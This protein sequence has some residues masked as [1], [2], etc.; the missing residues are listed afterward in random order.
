MSHPMVDIC[1]E[2]Q[3]TPINFGSDPLV[4]EVMETPAHT[5]SDAPIPMDEIP[6]PNDADYYADFAEWSGDR[7]RLI[8]IMPDGQPKPFLIEDEDRAD[9]CVN[10]IATWEAEIKRI[11]AQTARR[12]DRLTRQ[13]TNFEKRFLPELEQ[14]TRN[15]LAARGNKER[16]L[17]LL[18]G[19]CVLRSVPANVIVSNKEDA[20]N[21]LRKNPHDYEKMVTVTQDESL[22]ARAYKNLAKSTGELL[23][24]VEYTP[25]RETFTVKTGGN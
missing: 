14:Y 24:G 17:R 8:P 1:E 19:D 16:T 5:D 10:K 7:E 13:K 15:Q 2:Y 11:E 9:W 12:L 18:S 25:E 21:F 23:P 6:P 20:I 22:D 3:S 4:H